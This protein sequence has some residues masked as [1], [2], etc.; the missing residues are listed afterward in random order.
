MFPF[1]VEANLWAERSPEGR[2]L[3]NIRMGGGKTICALTLAKV[4]PETWPIVI[5][6]KAKLKMQW[7]MAVMEILGVPAQIV[8]GSKDRFYPGLFEVFI[9]SIDLARAIDFS[10][11]IGVAKTVIIDEVQTIKNRG[12]AR[13]QAVL[14][15]ARRTPFLWGLSGTPIKNRAGE[16]YS[17]LNLLDHN[18]F[19]SEKNFRSVWLWG[20]SIIPFR[21]D[22]FQKAIKPIV[23]TLERKDFGIQMPEKLQRPMFIQIEDKGMRKA[24]KKENDE[25]VDAYNMAEARSSTGKMSFTDSANLMAKIARLRHIT[26]VAK[27]PALV[28]HVEEF[29]DE[30]DEDDPIIVFYHHRAVQALLLDSL[31]PICKKMG[32]NTPMIFAPDVGKSR[33]DDMVAISARYHWVS[34]NPKKDR[35]LIASTLA[36][37]EGLNLQHCWKVVIGER[38]WND[39]NEQ[40]AQDRVVRIGA[41]SMS[42]EID[43]AIALGTVDEYLTGV[44]EGKRVGVASTEGVVLGESDLLREMMGKI[45]RAGKGAFT[46]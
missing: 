34:A 23:Y 10:S 5:L 15:L 22:N 13:T 2:V 37:G 12:A 8:E 14:D 24:Y 43:T 28:D 4:H 36:G 20:D 45:A 3:Y 6:C 16:Y 29:L 25:F 1:Q 31:T 11:L 32:I 27:V 9:V 7:F 17:M 30:Y 42:P 21:I 38:Q 46:L 18:L 41:R 39:P 19:P 35:V 40:Q 44:I 26:G 33:I